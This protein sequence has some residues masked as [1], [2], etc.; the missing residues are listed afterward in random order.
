[1]FASRTCVALFASRVCVA[2]YTALH[3]GTGRGGR[4]TAVCREVSS[5]PACQPEERQGPRLAAQE[6]WRHRQGSQRCALE[7]LPVVCELL[8]VVLLPGCLRARNPSVSRCLGVTCLFGASFR[9]AFAWF[10]T[11]PTLATS[12]T[13]GFTR[14]GEAGELSSLEK[15]ERAKQQSHMHWILSMIEQGDENEIKP[16]PHHAYSHHKVPP[17]ACYLHT[18]YRVCAHVAAQEEGCWIDR[19]KR[20]RAKM[21]QGRQGGHRGP[22]A[23]GF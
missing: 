12:R 11:A 13:S 16:A 1:M 17:P 3:R 23:G 2:C 8:P 10:V 9:P 20:G 14:T 22:L 18:R 6:G 7:L 19:A 4:N 15:K 21:L 5:V